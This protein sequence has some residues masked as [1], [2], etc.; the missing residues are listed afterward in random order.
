LFKYFWIKGRG[1]ADGPSSPLNNSLS[2]PDV[3]SS[4]LRC[5]DL[6]HR[7]KNPL[8]GLFSGAKLA[9]AVVADDHFLPG[10]SALTA[11]LQTVPKILVNKQ[12]RGE[13]EAHN[14]NNKTNINNIN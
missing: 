10:F 5:D 3:K 14:A 6:L 7:E 11:A 13:K 4:Q 9:A 12:V 8:R 1:K 2:I